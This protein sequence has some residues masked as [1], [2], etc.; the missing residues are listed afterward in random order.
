LIALL[1]PAVQA[2]REA[3]RRTQCASNMKQFVLAI[4]NHCDATKL[5]PHR[6][7]GSISAISPHVFLMPYYEQS[8]RFEA[9]K[10][11]G[12]PMQ[13]GAK[14]PERLSVLTTPLST[15]LC[16]SD[17]NARLASNVDTIYPN[18]ANAARCNIMV[19]FG[20]TIYSNQ[21][22]GGLSASEIQT[23][24]RGIVGYGRSFGFADITDGLS[25]T[26]A[27]S[28]SFS[29]NPTT[30][31]SAIKSGA[32]H[33][34]NTGELH[35]T[36]HIVCLVNGYAAGDKT[37]VATPAE[38]N[39]RGNQFTDGRPCATGVTTVLP[40]NTLSCSRTG[41]VS[42]GASGTW[43]VW[44]ATSFHPGIVNCG[45]ADGAVRTIPNSINCQSNPPLTV[46]TADNLWVG[47]SPYGVWG[48]FGCRNDGISISLP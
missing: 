42:Q 9:W 17:P 45:V 35:R 32:I 12:E 27:I 44:T 39:F 40:P 41:T 38:R 28:E 21:E 1:L 2:A 23:Y 33:N 24:Q 48:N 19:S 14:T 18:D 10:S 36:P 37:Q 15:L 13:G 5:L 43:G 31:P 7:A 8:A 11:L 34:A 26:M 6:T 25:N 30:N 16:P 46:T 47:P 3:A 22:D 4:H 20:D 29:T